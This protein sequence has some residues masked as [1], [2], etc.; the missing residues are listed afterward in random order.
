MEY[1]ERKEFLSEADLEKLKKSRKNTN[2][3][4]GIFLILLTVLT[5]IFIK[6][7]IAYIFMAVL[8]IIVFGIIFYVNKNMK[9]SIENGYK[10]IIKGT[11]TD[12]I[13]EQ[14]NSYGSEMNTS[15]YILFFGTN[16]V[17]VDYTN[18]NKYKIGET[19]E[20]HTTSKRDTIIFSQIIG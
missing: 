6:F 16:K 13:V 10:I 9:Q 17:K 20:L 7:T 11:I 15:N 2:I 4:F 12:K 18:Y 14:D 3:F 5:I 19:I 1:T 8:F